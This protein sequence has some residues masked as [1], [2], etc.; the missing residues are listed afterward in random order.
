MIPQNGEETKG[1]VHCD[2]MA[3]LSLPRQR[4]APA[5]SRRF[6]QPRLEA[7]G[8][9]EDEVYEILVAAGEAVNNA[10]LHGGPRDPFHPDQ[11]TIC[12]ST[13][14]SYLTIEVTSPRTGWPVSMPALPDPETEQGRGLYI[15]QCFTDSWSVTQDSKGTTVY[16]NRRLPQDGAPR[17]EP[18]ETGG[19]TPPADPPARQAARPTE[20]E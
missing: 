11:I 9:L 1:I 15:I 16:L 14:E 19:G 20:V 3:I 10:V 18:P 13:G 12:V 5:L 7:L 2:Y 8:Y 17:S 6:L 4:F